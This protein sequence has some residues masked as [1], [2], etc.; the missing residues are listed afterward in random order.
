MHITPEEIEAGRTGRGGW[1][2]ETLAKWGVPWPPP[3][4]WRKRLLA[5]LSPVSSEDSPRPKS[6]LELR[7]E[8]L[9]KKVAE[10]SDMLE[11]KVLNPDYIDVR[12][13]PCENSPTEVTELP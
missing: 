1:K 4:G 5:G 3:R 7:V 6:C 9:E 10:L 11:P 12:R 2:R 13:F 8:A